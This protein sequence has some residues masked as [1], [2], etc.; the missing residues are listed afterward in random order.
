MNNRFRTV[1]SAAFLLLFCGQV[2]S[3]LKYPETRRVDHRD[4]YHGVSVADPYRWLETDVR[5]SNEVA[6]WVAAQNAVTFTYLEG[7]PER[8]AIERRLTELWNY[9][10]Y[11][12]P[13]K[14]GG[15]YYYNKND[16]LQNQSVLYVMQN[17]DDEPKVLI[18]PNTWSG[19]GTIALAGTAFSDDGRFVAYGIAEAGSDWR[20]W[21]VMEIE[22][23]R[24][25]ED[26]LKWV[27]FSGIS[28]SRDSQGFYYGRYDKPEEG[29][30]FQ[31]LNLNQKLY[32]HRIATP[33]ADDNL[34]YQRPDEP[35]WTFGTGVTEDGRYLIISI[36][37]GTDARNRLI[38][39]DLTT[40]IEEVADQWAFL[41]KNL[42]MS[43]PS[44]YHVIP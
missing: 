13:F 24:L 18:D 27:K 6:E 36:G 32:Y 17:L 37:Q 21:R 4:V 15:R 1:V 23:G 25:L 20:T 19:D 31:S 39:I 14:I 33:Q 3:Q 40:S 10:R 11:S 26:E 7:I 34:V 41:V 9:E 44:K 16:G 8:K 38:Y 42:G 30:Q 35:E 2:Q 28:W 29:A 22:S 5:E 12:S 43:I